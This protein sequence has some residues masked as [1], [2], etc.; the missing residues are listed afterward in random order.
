MGCLRQIPPLRGQGI[1]QK[2]R[3]KD[4]ICK[5]QRG[6]KAQRLWQ[7]AQV[8]HRSQNWQRKWTL[9]PIP[10]P[11]A[12]W[13]WQPFTKEEFISTNK[14]SLGIQTTFKGRPHTQWYM[15][16]IKWT[17]WYFKILFLHIVWA[18]KILLAFCFLYCFWFCA[19][20][21]FVR[22]LMCL[23]TC[24]CLCVSVSSTSFFLFACLFFIERDKEGME[25]YIEVRRS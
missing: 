6:W 2:K 11:E 15:V 13:K 3:Q 23:C 14:V 19:F 16:D 20:M 7:H 10:N 22:M 18:L 21:G 17:Q 24:V 9:A 25:L 8:T 4:Y 1:M 5:C 12:V